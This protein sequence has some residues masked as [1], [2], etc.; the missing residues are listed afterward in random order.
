[1]RRPITIEEEMESLRQA[2]HYSNKEE[3]LKDAFRALLE[4]RPE[5]RISIAVELYKGGKISLNRAA[6]L[7]GV[8]AEEMKEILAGRGVAL[9]R[10]LTKPE[11]RRARAEE[12]AR[13]SK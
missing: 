5:L 10:G 2:G 7:A 4:S 6:R 13:L 3:I 9:K 11:E 12:L 8:T 1:M